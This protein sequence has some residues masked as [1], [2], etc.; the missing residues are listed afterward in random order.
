MG[1]NLKGSFEP[2]VT[3]KLFNIVQLILDGKAK[4]LPIYKK[5]NP[6][7]PLRGVLRCA[8]CG[9]Y[10]TSNWSQGKYKKYGYYRCTKCSGINLG[11]YDVEE[12][13]IEYLKEI[14]LKKDVGKLVKEAIILNWKNRTKEIQSKVNL[15]KK[16]KRTLRAK[17]DKVVE[18]NLNGI[19]NDKLSK[20]YIGD[21]EEKISKIDIELTRYSDPEKD[22]EK[23]I[24]FSVVLLK[25]MSKAWTKMDEFQQNKFEKFIFPQGLIYKNENFT[26]PTKPL[27]VELNEAFE[28]KNSM[29]VTPR[30]IEPLSPG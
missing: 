27:S 7:F 3:P 15:L 10:L 9:N 17:Q 4:K 25:N 30:G 11:K 19:Y 1:L 20:R 23:L 29:M 13:F 16:E 12:N 21:L 6:D 24:K 28:V 14:K 26:T 22:E 18:K 2:I 8:K 5:I